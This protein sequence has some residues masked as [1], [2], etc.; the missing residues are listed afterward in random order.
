MTS[1]SAST[2]RGGASIIKQNHGP[3]KCAASREFVTLR[4]TENSGPATFRP[5]FYFTLW[6]AHR[7]F[8]MSMRFG[9]DI[10]LSRSTKTA[11]R[12]SK[13]KPFPEGHARG[14]SIPSC[15]FCE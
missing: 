10:S 7:E 14:A 6:D 15:E 13:D 11:G 12:G 3:L 2:A 4:T 5:A 1:K 9:F 8:A